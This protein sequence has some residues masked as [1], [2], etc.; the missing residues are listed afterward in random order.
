MTARA[1]AD[2]ARAFLV[3]RAQSGDRDALDALLRELQEPL[4]RHVL[5][6]VRDADVAKDVLQDAL[7]IICRKLGWLRDPRWLRAWAYR[8]ATREAVRRARRDRRRLDAL[9]DDGVL[10]AAAAE[11]PEPPPDEA[12]LARLPALLASLSPASAVVLRLHYLDGLTHV[13]IAEALEIAVGTVKSR[14]AY[15]L[16]ALRTRLAGG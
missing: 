11:P 5:A 1:D 7:W 12:L 8:I 6:I 2:R 15:G 16:A 9:T 13:E 10:P 4:Y 3:A 14:L